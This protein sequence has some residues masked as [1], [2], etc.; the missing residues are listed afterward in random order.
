VLYDAEP[1]VEE[2]DPWD[3]FVNDN[4]DLTPKAARYIDRIQELVD[5]EFILFGIGPDEK[6]IIELRD[7]FEL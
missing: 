3:R 5:R 1:I 2:F 4:G 6:D 7:A